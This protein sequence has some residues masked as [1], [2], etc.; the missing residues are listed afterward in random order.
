M[1][2]MNIIDLIDKYEKCDSEQE[3]KTILKEN[4]RVEK[5]IPFL[6][7]KEVIDTIINNFIETDNGL[8]TYEPMSKH[9]NFTLGFICLYTNL[10]YDDGFGVTAYD[11][12]TRYNIVDYIIHEIGYDYGD[13]VNMFEE[14]LSMRINYN[15]SISNRISAV[16][17]S[18]EKLINEI[19]EES[20]KELA[21]LLENIK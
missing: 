1:D 20:L 12:L 14:T 16:F 11:L 21:D 13:F 8:L 5:Y 19:P 2:E 7:K 3:R 10:S 9:L 18:I 4:I 17:S 15:N 6:A